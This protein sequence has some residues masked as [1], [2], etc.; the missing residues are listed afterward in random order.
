MRPLGG[1]LERLG[2]V[3]GASWG[4]LG[5]SWGVTWASWGHLVPHFQSKA[6]LNLGMLSW[7][8]FFNRLNEFASEFR[9]P[10]LE[11]SLN[12]IR[13]IIRLSFQIILT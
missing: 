1:V 12:S 5:A 3:L 4:V 13:K 6:W 2:G 8:A 11:K 7:M 9:P 10:N